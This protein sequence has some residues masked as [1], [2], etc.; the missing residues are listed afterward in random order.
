MSAAANILIDCTCTMKFSATDLG[1]GSESFS[2]P[3]SFKADKITVK[4]SVT[5]ADHSTNQDDVAFHRKNKTDWEIDVE[6]K[7]YSSTLLAAL[8]ANALGE[9]IV[10]APDG[11]GVDGQGL[12][13][14]LDV[15]YAGPSTMKWSLKARGAALSYT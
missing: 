3:I 7:L 9:I 11:M 12:I 6:T 1:T 8:R 15:D 5:S 14:G 13:M 4:E 2:G 10:T